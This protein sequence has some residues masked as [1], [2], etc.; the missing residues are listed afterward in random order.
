M[1]G[2]RGIEYRGLVEPL[3][4][5]PSNNRRRGPAINSSRPSR[6]GGRFDI[7]AGVADNASSRYPFLSI[8]S[9]TNGGSHEI[10][11]QQTRRRFALRRGAGR[12]GV[13]LAGS[14]RGCGHRRA[15]L[16]VGASHRQCTESRHR[17]KSRPRCGTA[18]RHQPHRVRGDGFRRDARASGSVDAEPAEPARHFRQG[19]RLGGDE[20]QRRGR[21]PRHVHAATVR[22]QAR[23]QVHR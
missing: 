4:A 15:Q 3:A 14:G 2:L 22:R 19:Q 16:A 6:G 1:A 12:A 5:C 23:R 11:S 10:N 20:P 7:G 13:H 9:A 18:K 21:V 17:G 8:F